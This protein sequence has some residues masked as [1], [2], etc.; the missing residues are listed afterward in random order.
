[1]AGHAFDQDHGAIELAPR[2]V[3]SR[4]DRARSPLLR[5][6]AATR[7]RRRAAAG[8]G[9]LA[10]LV[11][12][13]VRGC[14]AGRR[15]ARAR[16]FGS[17]KRRD[18]PANIAVRHAG[19]GDNRIGTFG[20]LCDASTAARAKPP[21]SSSGSP[22]T[23]ASGMRMPRRSATLLTVAMRSLPA[24]ARIAAVAREQ[25]RA[26]H[27][28]ASGE[29]Q[30]AALGLLVAV[31]DRRERVTSVRAGRAASPCFTASPSWHRA[32]RSS[33]RPLPRAARRDSTAPARECTSPSRRARSHKRRCRS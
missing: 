21:S 17:S 3:R 4:S 24:P 7:A 19:P 12:S 28:A 31:D 29:D 11:A 22:T 5:N 32:R 10:T 30:D 8:S 23:I 27:V 25:R 15:P 13:A 6:R 18:P 16:P 20:L 1:M 14:A 26:G 9:G 33:A 2:D